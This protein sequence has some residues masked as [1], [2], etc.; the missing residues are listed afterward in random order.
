[1]GSLRTG[2]IV[3]PR[4]RQRETESFMTPAQAR[5]WR[6]RWKA[7]R[8]AEIAELRATPLSVKLRQL[9]ALMAS[10][11]LFPRTASE[12]HEEQTVRSRWIRLYAA[13]HG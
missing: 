3:R 6:A 5:A 12:D 10:A 2:G 4:R 8:Q 7:M 13:F 1:M 9:D 11:S